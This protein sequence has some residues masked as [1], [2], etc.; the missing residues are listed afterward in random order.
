[1]VLDSP[2]PDCKDG[3]GERKVALR[4]FDKAAVCTRLTAASLPP[5]LHLARRSE[6]ERERRHNER[7][8]LF[9]SPP[10]LSP[11]SC[12]AKNRRQSEQRRSVELLF[13]ATSNRRRTEKRGYNYEERRTVRTTRNGEEH[14]ALS[15]RLRLRV[16]S[17]A[18][19][20]RA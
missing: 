6:V 9:F 10:T 13:S 5:Q 7:F 8:F 18:V 11:R 4:P 20:S 16:Y 19:K 15:P 2:G 3:E 12:A 17:S 1:V 14:A